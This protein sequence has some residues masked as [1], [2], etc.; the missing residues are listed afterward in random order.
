MGHEGQL[1][2]DSDE[3]DVEYVDDEVLEAMDYD[4][5]MDEYPNTEGRDALW[6]LRQ[7][8]PLY[9]VSVINTEPL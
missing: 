1:P 5:E 8:N 4:E 2:A 3:D 7:E 9:A 6:T